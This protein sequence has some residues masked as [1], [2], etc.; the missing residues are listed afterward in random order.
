VTPMPGDY[1]GVNSTI[2]RQKFALSVT[3][4]APV[5]MTGAAPLFKGAGDAGCYAAQDTAKRYHFPRVI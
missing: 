5:V 4:A 2:R 3:G 1:S